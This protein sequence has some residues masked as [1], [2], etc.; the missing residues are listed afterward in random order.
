MLHARLPPVAAHVDAWMRDSGR[1]A[2]VIA[3]SGETFLAHTF[4]RRH[5]SL[6]FTVVERQ[7]KLMTELASASATPATPASP[8]TPRAARA[9]RDRG[10]G[11]LPSLG[12]A[13]RLARKRPRRRP[14]SS[15]RF[16]RT[17]STTS[18]QMGWS[19][20]TGQGMLIQ[21]SLMQV[22]SHVKHLEQRVRAAEQEQQAAR[23]SAP[24]GDFAG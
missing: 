14:K 20:S 9:G 3:A 12:E 6:S 21:N 19:R 18:R 4:K 23:R 22:H 13:S 17:T 24:A 15:S 8:A 1:P 10:G 16:S 7:D 2:V 5:F 11:R